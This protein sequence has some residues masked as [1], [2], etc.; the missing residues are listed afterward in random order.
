VTQSPQP[1]IAPPPSPTLRVLGYV[2]LLAAGAGAVSHWLLYLMPLADY[3]KPFI[4]GAY[5]K[6]SVFLSFAV[7]VATFFHYRRTRMPATLVARVLAYL[8][9]AAIILLFRAAAR[10]AS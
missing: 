10:A 5:A 3:G 6:V 9:I 1:E 4:L 2:L 7:L 8:W